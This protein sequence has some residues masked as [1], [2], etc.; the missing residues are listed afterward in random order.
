MDVRSQSGLFLAEDASA[1]AFEQSGNWKWISL[2]DYA[3]DEQGWQH[4]V[5]P[6]SDFMGLNISDNIAN[7]AI[8]FW[9][10][11]DSDYFIDNIRLTGEKTN[12]IESPSDLQGSVIS[13]HQIDLSWVGNSPKY[14]VYRDGTLI[15]TVQ[16]LTYS[17][18]SLEEATSYAFY[19]T[20]LSESDEESL[21]TESLILTTSKTT[22][23]DS[24][25][26]IANF[27]NGTGEGWG[28]NPL[29]VPGMESLYALRLIGEGNSAVGIEKIID[30]VITKDHTNLEF[31]LNLNGSYFY[32]SDAEVSFDQNGWRTLSLINYIEN[33][34]SGWQHVVIPLSDFSDLNPNEA[35]ARMIFRFWNS[36]SSTVDIDNIMLK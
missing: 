12:E 3:K 20:A 23:P 24:S 34:K 31:D 2:S 26:I 17:A 25:F 4:V 1:V 15:A 30:S 10:D 29:L 11:S 35:I 27:E 9:N 5:I 14:N 16:G 33:G 21:P 22:A 28:E 8:R 18:E 13:D 7:L 6:L 32:S 36:D 19:I